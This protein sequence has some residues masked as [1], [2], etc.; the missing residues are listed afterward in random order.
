MKKIYESPVAEK[1]EFNYADQVVASNEGNLGG[2]DDGDG[3]E[4]TKDNYWFF[5]C[6]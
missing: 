1:I 6:A 3:K 5:T 2:S 4:K